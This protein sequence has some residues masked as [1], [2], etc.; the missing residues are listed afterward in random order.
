MLF[1]LKSLKKV[2]IILKRGK[3][4]IFEILFVISLL[5]LTI[6]SAEMT[7]PVNG[8]IQTPSTIG[9][10][11]SATYDV[12]WSGSIESTYEGEW[13]LLNTQYTGTLT[14][15][16]ADG[17]ATWT[18]TE[19]FSGTSY[20]TYYSSDGYAG[21]MSLPYSDSTSYSVTKGSMGYGTGYG[22]YGAFV[23]VP[24]IWDVDPT[25]VSTLAAYGIDVSGSASSGYYASGSDIF[26]YPGLGTVAWSFMGYIDSSGWLVYCSSRYDFALSSEGVTMIAGYSGMVSMTGT[27]TGF[28]LGSTPEAEPIFDFI[29]DNE[30]HT[31]D[32]T[33]DD[34]TAKVTVQ[35]EGNTSIM[36]SIM[37]PNDIPESAK[38]A[39]KG[40][41][42]P[43]AVVSVDLGNPSALQYIEVNVT[44]SDL[45]VSDPEN[46]RMYYYDIIDDT[47]K[48]MDETGVDTINEVVWGRIDH[49]TLYSASKPEGSAGGG[50]PGFEF[51]VLF[52]AILLPVLIRKRR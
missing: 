7:I 19:T 47:W 6:L 22:G 26:S 4:G 20:M 28:T 18:V 31:Y 3:I 12:T 14:V 23:M 30:E 44:Y 9:D 25:T 48:Q 37:S 11:Q 50:A 1:R 2:E 45:G 40:K 15:S 36:I 34:F 27:P 41:I 29:D 33:T 32:I 49:T 38:D 46:L 21:S 16:V 35:C 39:A 52:P 43:Y 8:K 51:I 17:G 13:A 24:I 5:V 10:G 42:T